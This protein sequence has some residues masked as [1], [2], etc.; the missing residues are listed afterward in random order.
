VAQRNCCREN[1]DR[2]DWNHNN[3]SKRHIVCVRKDIPL[4]QQRG[5]SSGTQWYAPPLPAATSRSTSR[6]RVLP[7]MRLCCAGATRPRVSVRQCST[8]ER[9]NAHKEPVPQLHIH[10]TIF[11]FEPCASKQMNRARE[12]VLNPDSSCKKAVLDRKMCRTVWITCSHRQPNY[13]RAPEAISQNAKIF[14][15]R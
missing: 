3:S 12:Q 14:D 1:N 7:W 10:L 13:L 4:T 5:T 8:D 9:E 6:W 15:T 11:A 2:I